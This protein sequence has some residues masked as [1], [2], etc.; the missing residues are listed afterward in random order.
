MSQAKNQRKVGSYEANNLS[1]LLENYT[2][3]PYYL[4]TLGTYASA[5][6]NGFMGM[7]SVRPCVLPYTYICIS[8]C[9]LYCENE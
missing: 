3:L 6:A 8:H 1:L 5:F 9:G 7:L 4:G 2:T